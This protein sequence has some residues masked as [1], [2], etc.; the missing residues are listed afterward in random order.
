MGPSMNRVEGSQDITSQQ[1]SRL[2]RFVVKVLG[3]SAGL[4]ELSGP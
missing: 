4:A 3:T 2:V 1:R